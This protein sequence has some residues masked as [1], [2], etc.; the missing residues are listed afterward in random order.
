MPIKRLLSQG[1][2]ITHTMPNTYIE[3]KKARYSLMGVNSKL[4]VALNRLIVECLE[5]IF[6]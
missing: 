6:V 5:I 2:N 3:M 4:P 1:M